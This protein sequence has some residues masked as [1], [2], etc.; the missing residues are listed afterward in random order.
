MGGF[1]VYFVGRGGQM[2]MKGVGKE[3]IKGPGICSRVDSGMIYSGGN[4][5]EEVL[6]QVKGVYICD[7]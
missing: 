5:Y 6:G 4:R 2:E 7:M 1:E 3:A